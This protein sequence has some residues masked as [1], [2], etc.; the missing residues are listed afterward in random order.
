MILALALTLV[1]TFALLVSGRVR[2][3][4]VS[5]GLIA[6]LGLSGLLTPAQA[7]SGFASQATLAV[8]AMLA[9]SAG[10]ER[11]GV[12]EYLASTLARAAGTSLW[13]VLLAL[14]LPTVLL[15]AFMN[16]TAI[17][18]LMIP[19]TLRLARRGGHKPSKLLLPVSYLSILGGTSTL[20]GT[21]TNLL[22]DSLAREA[23]RP[24]F[25]MFEFTGLGL[26]YL[27]VGVLYM[28]LIGV[29]LLPERTGFTDLLSV[30]A[31]G[32]FVTEIVVR[33]GSRHVGRP[34]GEVFARGRDIQVLELVRGE[35]PILGPGVEIVLVPDDVLYVESTAQNLNQLLADPDVEPGT[36]VA[37]DERV[38]LGEFLAG[39]MTPGGNALLVSGDNAH[40]PR[41][42]RTQH[43]DLRM[44]EAVITPSSRFVG[45]PVRELGL[46]RRHGVHVIAIRR[47]GRQH[48]YNLR[49]LRLRP[50]DVLLLQGEPAALRGI[51]DEGDFLLIEGIERT[52]TFP[53]KAPLAIGI[54]V[55]VVALAS[56]NVAPFALLAL[57]GAAAMLVGGCMG[58]RDATRALDPAVLLLIAAMIPL[59][60]AMEE[61]GLATV[62]AE[63]VVSLAGAAG[64]VVLV[65]ALY[66]LTSVMTEFLSNNAAA[67][68]L[69]PIC[70][71]IAARMGI[72][73]E[74]LLIAITFGASA[75]FATPIGYQTNT[76]VMGPGGY[77][78]RDYLR[79]GVP[80]NLILW[81]AASLLIPYFWQP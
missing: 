80:L 15:S 31:P 56:L 1:A 72:A 27:L 39:E 40:A 25:G 30:Q 21:S 73:P 54:L 78:F 13:R 68:L 63:G 41:E 43:V 57:A 51:H 48:Q 33:A 49:R 77:T 42:A 10:L 46:S 34:L 79:V 26:A 59:G 71:Q 36:A 6:F 55:V 24:G 70:L 9:L 3:E 11:T 7:L 45:R 76:M 67:V 47:L 32:R 44:A 64:P 53:R 20:I 61:A 5:L 38:P 75:S 66:L 60:S 65:S 69:T 12:V 16:N 37:D 35:E 74:P 23:G 28:A 18:A 50:G 14:G 81:L 29:R 17:V 58:V 52:L 4:I 8:A 2:V 19:V 62:I 22:V